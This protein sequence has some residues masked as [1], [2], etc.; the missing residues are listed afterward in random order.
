[1]S[2][3]CSIGTLAVNYVIDLHQLGWNPGGY[4]GFALLDNRQAIRW[5][6]SNNCAITKYDHARTRI[7]D[8]FYWLD[9]LRSIHA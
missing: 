7:S 5:A 9:D 1:M 8:P 6:G 3:Q 2:A 4:M